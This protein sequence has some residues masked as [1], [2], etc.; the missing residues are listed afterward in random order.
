M[1]VFSFG[2]RT[3]KYKCW[4]YTLACKIQDGDRILYTKINFHAQGKL[5]EC[6]SPWA[7][8]LAL[9]PNPLHSCWYAAGSLKFTRWC[10]SC[11]PGST[12][13][14]LVSTRVVSVQSQLWRC[15]FQEQQLSWLGVVICDNKGAVIGALSMHI[16][17]PQSVA[18]VEALACRRAV[19]FAIEIGLHEGIFEGDAAV[20]IQATKTWS[21]DQS[22]CGHHWW[23]PWTSIPF[24]S[25]WFLL[26][27][28]C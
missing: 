13:S 10:P 7:F 15:S 2:A 18:E 20:V 8:D 25:V 14:S 1:L 19:Q 23:H 4:F 21:A 16:P 26:C 5:K 11:C 9:E 3:I 27:Q 6:H 12:R 24:V 22:M 28:L 17:L